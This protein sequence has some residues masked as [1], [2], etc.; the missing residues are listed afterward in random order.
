LKKIAV[1]FTEILISAASFS[2]RRGRCKIKG[3]TGT[4]HVHSLG[5]K[6]F[7]GSG[8][9]KFIHAYAWFDAQVSL[10]FTLEQPVLD[11]DPDGYGGARSGFNNRPI[12]ADFETPS[13]G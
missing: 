8:S 13:A 11:P 2:Q 1:H 12:G 7:L 4:S 9:Q 5:V 6:E 3:S 10:E